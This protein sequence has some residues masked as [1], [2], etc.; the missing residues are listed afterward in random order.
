MKKQRKQVS[1]HTGDVQVQLHQHV[2]VTIKRLGINGEGVGYYRRKLIF[3]P[4]ALPTEVVQAEIS[5]IKPRYLRGTIR[6]IDKRSQ[7][8]TEPRDAYATTVGGLELEVLDYPQQLKFKRDLVKQ[9]LS[10]YHPRGFAKYDVRPVIGMQHPYE[11]RN[12][13]QFQVRTAQ[14][15]H[16]IAGLYR[17]GTHDVVDM[18]TCA[19]QDPVTMKV[20]RAVVAMVE[21]LQIPTYDEATNTGILKTIV[22]RAAHNTDQVQLVFITHAN[23]LLK[24]RQLIWRIAEELPEVTSIMHNVNPGTSPLIWGDKTNRLAGTETITEKINGLDFRLSA[25]AF[26]QLNSIMTP[27]LYDLASQALALAPTDRLVDA[28]AGVGTIGLTLAKQVAEVRGMETIPE[29]VSDARQ[30]ASLNHID[31]AEYFTGKAEDLLPE[32]EAAGW[33]PDALVVDPPRVGLDQRLIATILKTRPRKFV[34]VSCNQSTLAQDLVELSK[35][36][37][38]DYLQPVDMLPQTPH[39]E[40]V[41]KLTRKD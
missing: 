33:Q 7:F 10:R 36:Y 14:D 32:W 41:V 9:A 25:R 15:G 28:Y 26:L 21:E 6:Q 24:Q 18:E 38:V 34:Y 12:K 8:R 35:A 37:N 19:V 16:V 22:V 5:E 29:A 17:E 40:I 39:I 30:N 2:T 20:M 31:N 23:K 1:H 3:I 13:A 11:Y 27:K 4:G